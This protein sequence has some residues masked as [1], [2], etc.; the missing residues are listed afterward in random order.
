MKR[1]DMPQGS[2]EWWKARAGRPTGSEFGRI[3]TPKTGKPAAAQDGYINELIAESMGWRKREFS[4]SPDIERGHLLE[5]EA[6]QFLALEIGED[7]EEIGFALSECG[8]YGCSPDGITK[9][10]VPVEL[11]CPDTHTVV[12]YIRGTELPSEYKCQVHG[13][14]ILTGS[15]HAWFCAYPDY[16]NIDEEYRNRFHPFVIKVERD[17]FTEKLES[18]L[19]AFCDRLDEEKLK[20]IAD[21]AY[22]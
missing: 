18:E 11:K 1:L 22:L 3:L 16:F 13:H 2:P 12:G 4:G 5:D 7:I 17:D 15:G 6:R 9:S 19:E 14:M 10:G 21:P 20:V 8:R